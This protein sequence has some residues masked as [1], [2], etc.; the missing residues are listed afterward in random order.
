MS[1][2]QGRIIRLEESVKTLYSYS[3]EGFSFSGKEE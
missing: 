1:E 3:V 2:R